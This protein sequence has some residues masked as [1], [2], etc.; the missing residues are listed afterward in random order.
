VAVHTRRREASW[1]RKLGYHIYG[2]YFPA[3][4]SKLLKWEMWLC[5][6]IHTYI[7]YEPKN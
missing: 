2:P 5:I 1:P 3:N 6:Y 7:R 4:T